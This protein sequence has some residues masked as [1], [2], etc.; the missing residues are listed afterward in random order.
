MLVCVSDSMSTVS[1]S[2]GQPAIVVMRLRAGTPASSPRAALIR[3]GKL[4][5]GDPVSSTSTQKNKSREKDCGPLHNVATKTDR[6]ISRMLR[7]TRS[8]RIK[9]EK[10]AVQNGRVLHY[11]PPALA[12]DHRYAGAPA[13]SLLLFCRRPPTSL[14]SEA[15]APRLQDSLQP[16][17]WPPYLPEQGEHAAVGGHDHGLEARGARE[18]RRRQVVAR[19]EA[20]ERRL[21]EVR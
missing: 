4:D 17:P 14:E 3:F 8:S 15:A 1:M 19:G 7:F 12:G 13:A 20:A 11:L 5:S 16:H 2:A 18:R 21:T 9:L 6:Q 10:S